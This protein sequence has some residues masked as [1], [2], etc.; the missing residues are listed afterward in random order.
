MNVIDKILQRPEFIESP[1]VLIDVGASSGIHAAWKHIAK[2]SICVAFD[3]DDRGMGGTHRETKTYRELHV[4]D[5][6][7]TSGEEQTAD[8][9]LTAD[10]P[11]S[12]MLPPDA[13][14]LASWEFSDRFKVIKKTRVKTIHLQRVLS[15]LKLDRVDWFKTDSQGTDLRLFLSLPDSVVRRVMVAEFEPGI[16]DAYQGE[17]KLW[18]V[19]ARMDEMGFWMSDLAVKGSSRI[20]KDLIGNFSNIEKK[21]MV[22]LLKSSPGWA[23]ATYLN[24]FATAEFTKR[25]FLLGWVVGTLHRQHGYAME[26]AMSAKHQVGDSVFDELQ[27]ASLQAIRKRYFDFPAYLPLARR[28]FRRWKRLRMA[29]SAP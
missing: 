24:S 26:L 15:E 23:E 5:R 29:I 2:Y 10:A 16:I 7:L 13:E 4:Y 6:A 28:A 11:C 18:Q 20:R 1:P 17:D 21:Y 12:S 27:H 19:M 8:F 9:Y 22:H 14:G 25:D 3:A